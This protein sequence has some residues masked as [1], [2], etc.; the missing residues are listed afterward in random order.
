MTLVIDRQSIEETVQQVADGD[1]SIQQAAQRL[2][3]EPRES[4]RETELESLASLTE[5]LGEPPTEVVDHWCGQLRN[6]LRASKR[7]DLST[8]INNVDL[9][10]FAVTSDGQIRFADETLVT[11]HAVDH[12]EFTFDEIERLIDRFRANL[13]SCKTNPHGP[14]SDESPPGKGTQTSLRLKM[15]VGSGL[16]LCCVA[17]LWIANAKRTTT[18]SESSFTSTDPSPTT[19]DRAPAKFPSTRS[20]FAGQK[21]SNVSLESLESMSDE[22]ISLLESSQVPS[23][24]LDALM[25]GIPD[26][27]ASRPVRDIQ[28]RSDLESE[29]VSTESKQDDQVEAIQK[30]LG[31]KPATQ[32]TIDKEPDPKVLSDDSLDAKQPDELKQATRNATSTAITL[33][34]LNQVKPIVLNDQAQ[35]VGASGDLT[36]RFPAN[37]K[38]SIKQHHD[39]NIW[40]IIDQKGS[41]LVG[42]IDATTKELKF[43][44]AEGAEKISGARSLLNGRLI[45]DDGSGFFLRPELQADP[46]PIRLDQPDMR[47]TW[48]LAAPL[49]PTVSRMSVEIEL[50]DDLEMTWVEP[51]PLDSPRRA[52]GLAILQPL[53][54]ESVDLAIKFDVRCS[55]KLSCRLRYAARLDSS[56]PWQLVSRDLLEAFSNQL[57]GRAGLVSRE[58]DRLQNVYEMA[59]TRGKRII[60]MKQKHN[61]GLADSLREYADRVA[62]LQSLIASVE[63]RATLKFRVWVLWPSGEEQT[64]FTSAN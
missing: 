6:S 26:P 40:D 41:D 16:V 14:S 13:A 38:L 50:P 56:M 30:G 19:P 54:G 21:Q 53:D 45:C 18:V 22:E 5:R 51:I 11:L 24:S 42:T 25:P 2:L 12:P 17:L 31:D 52:R 64:V 44:W 23:F 29:S 8:T 9:T 10:D 33:P 60:R 4:S 1:I 55:R 27:V 48:Q 32:L 35:G 43:A 58:A 47:P 57:A 34:P 62:Q 3:D 20:N 36:L 15:V 39:K 63:S 7:A 61:D 59:G 46:W 37:P 28:N 49:P